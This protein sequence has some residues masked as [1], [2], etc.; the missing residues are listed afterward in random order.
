[1]AHLSG[2]PQDLHHSKGHD[3][4]LAGK[5][6]DD[7]ALEAAAR[8]LG[9]RERQATTALG[10]ADIF[11][12][13]VAEEWNTGNTEVFERPPRY[14]GDHAVREFR[15]CSRLAHL[16]SLTPTSSFDNIQL[17]ADRSA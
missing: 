1:M 13:L 15:G 3:L 17:P 9:K 6:D 11:V 5:C 16:A 7:R 2:G 4:L 8:V 14:G 12:G 10:T